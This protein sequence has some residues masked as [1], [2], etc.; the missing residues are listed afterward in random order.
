MISLV[1]DISMEKR[2]DNIMFT[3]SMSYKYNST[4]NINTNSRTV[5]SENRDQVVRDKQ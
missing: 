4:K 2:L 3:Q 1:T 5:L